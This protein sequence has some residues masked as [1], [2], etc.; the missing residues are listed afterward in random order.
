MKESHEAFTTDK[1]KT[2]Q[3]LIVKEK[4]LEEKEKR[5]VIHL[6][7]I[8]FQESIEEEYKQIYS[9]KEQEITDGFEHKFKELESKFQQEL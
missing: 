6:S 3:E 1:A 5:L 9:K 4:Y 7:I 2:E 8:I